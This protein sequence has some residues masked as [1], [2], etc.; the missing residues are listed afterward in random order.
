MGSQ[1]TPTPP[2]TPGHTPV[3]S[4]TQTEKTGSQSD[5]AQRTMS[6]SSPARSKHECKLEIGCTYV[7]CVVWSFIVIFCSKVN[8]L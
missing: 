7:N 1:P 8:L 3:R 2:S 4:Y 5:I 6:E